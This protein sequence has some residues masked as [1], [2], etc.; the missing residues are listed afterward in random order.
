M[1]NPMTVLAGSAALGYWAIS[2]KVGAAREVAAARVAI[3]LAV[4]G[5]GAADGADS[6]L[7]AFR[8]LHR[9]S[10]AH[11]AYLDNEQREEIRLKAGSIAETLSMEIPAAAH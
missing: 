4:R 2:G 6:L 5:Q 9:M 10:D 1:I 3:L 7:N 11:L 8:G